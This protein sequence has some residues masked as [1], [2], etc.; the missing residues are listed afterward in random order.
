[1]RSTRLK[2]VKLFLWLLPAVLLS[3]LIYSISKPDGLRLAWPER[4]RHKLLLYDGPTVELFQNKRLEQTFRANYPGLAQINILFKAGDQKTEG[5]LIIFR[6]KQTCNSTE[7]IVH[8]STTLSPYSGLAFHPFRFP[9]IDSSTNQIYCLVL[10][11]P[12]ATTDRLVQLQL[13]EGDLYPH[14]MLQVH[15]PRLEQAG[16][17]P[18]SAASVVNDK[19]NLPYKVYLPTISGEPETSSYRQDIGF[20][21]HYRGLLLPTVQAL[22]TRLT[23]N[24]PYILGAPW[25]YGG[26]VGVYAGLLAALFYLARKTIQLDQ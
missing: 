26:L 7:D 20:Q 11:A 13:S 15:R 21:L 14:G 18:K 12:A 25:F 1:M 10:E 19:A 5:Q 6:L 16:D 17:R 2:T 3:G 24:K 22:I 4:T 9:P 23:A 8:I